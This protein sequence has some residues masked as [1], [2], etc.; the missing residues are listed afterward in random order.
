MSIDRPA[1]ERLE[2]YE[3][4]KRSLL[5]QNDTEFFDADDLIIIIDQ[6]VDL[7]DSYVQIEALMR[8]Y[9]F[10]PENEELANRRAFLYYDLNI[11]AGVRTM[12][13][14]KT[15]DSPLWDV[16]KLR[17]DENNPNITDIAKAKLEVLLQRPN[18]FDDE[19]I[20]QLVDCASACGLYNWLKDNEKQLREKTDFLQ[21][22]L[23][24]LFIVADMQGDY[25]YGIKLLEELTELEPFNV[26]FWGALA[27]TQCNAEQ[28]D[29][30][31]TSIEYALAI[32]PQNIGVI[33]LKAS[34]F[35]RQ[36]EFYKALNTI[37]SAGEPTALLAELKIRALYTMGRE[38]E[39]ESITSDYNLIFPED[40]GIVDM[41]LCMRVHYT[42]QALA[43][44]HK[45]VSKD[46]FSKWSEWAAAHYAEGRHFAASKI[47]QYLRKY[48]MLNFSEY[49]M[50]ASALYCDNNYEE[51]AQLLDQAI[52]SEEKALVPDVVIAG[53]LSYAK[54]GKKSEA[55]SVFEKVMQLF[56]LSIKEE[57]TLSSTLESIGFSSF[58]SLYH[59]VLEKPG[60]ID[61]RELDIFHFPLSANYVKD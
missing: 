23:Y 17:L 20:I 5:E 26:D 59:N 52:E 35:I 8:G 11:D 10:F 21:T 55:K 51:A 13:N 41:A 43:N 36:E 61:T 56:P 32:D 22:L 9:R 29:A 19:S 46:D 6:A 54:L 31:L 47:L 4:F 25:T 28:L 37:N 38:Q 2:L 60:E 40:Q 44:H 49:K 3:R 27:Q 58:L 14:Q 30:A 1:N 16:L 45:A 7:E 48:D 39:A 42:E 18:K 57:W 24:E 33:A 12:V 53:L 15:D 50:L 34:I